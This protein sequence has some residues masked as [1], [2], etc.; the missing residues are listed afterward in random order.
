VSLSFG[1]YSLTRLKSLCLAGHII[2]HWVRWWGEPWTDRDSALRVSAP[3]RLCGFALK[4]V[5]AFLRSFCYLL[6]IPAYSLHWRGAQRL[7]QDAFGNLL[8]NGKARI[9]DLANEIGL[10]GEQFDN[11][12]LAKAEFAQALLHFRGR[13]ELFDPH[14]YSGLDAVQRTN[15]APSFIPQRLD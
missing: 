13:A 10:A 2:H 8:A 7:D 15:L 14:G 6:L 3:L 9:A 11:V 5:S 12:V 1:G 4:A